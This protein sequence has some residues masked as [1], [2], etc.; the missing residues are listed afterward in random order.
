M[1]ENSRGQNRNGDRQKSVGPAPRD[2]DAGKRNSSAGRLR[3]TDIDRLR[4]D[5]R[6]QKNSGIPGK[7]DISATDYDGQ[8]SD[9]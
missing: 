6:T 3:D 4:N 2:G 8:L 9:E 5:N 7:T 1:A